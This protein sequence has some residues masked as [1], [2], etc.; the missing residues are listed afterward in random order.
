MT[1][2]HT[3]PDGETTVYKPKDTPDAIVI[4]LLVA[5]LMAGL[6]GHVKDALE[7]EVVS[8]DESQSANDLN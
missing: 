4:M 2:T 7:R 5:R 8:A 6:H 3:I 1:V